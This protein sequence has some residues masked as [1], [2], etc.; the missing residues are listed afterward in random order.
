MTSPS[1]FTPLG[2]EA[3]VLEFAA[4]PPYAPSSGPLITHTPYHRPLDATRLGQLSWSEPLAEDRLVSDEG[5][6]A[7][8]LLMNVYESDMLFLPS[9]GL[10][11][12]EEAFSSFYDQRRRQNA[13]LVRPLV[14]SFAFDFLDRSVRITGEWTIDALHA[15][16][17][18]AIDETI[19]ADSD[20]LLAI[21]TSA[22]RRR[23]AEMLLAQMALDGLTE[24][25]AMSQNLGGAYGA[26]QS[27]LFKIFIDE[28]GYGVFDTKHSTLFGELCRSIGMVADAHRYWFFYLPSWIASNNYFYYVTRNRTAFFRYVGGMAYL[29]AT[30]AP[31]FAAMTRV[32]R[33]IYGGTVDTR[34]CD[35]HAHIDQHHGRMAVEDLLLPMARKHGPLAIQD[36]V[37]GIEE[38]RLLGRIADDDL[39][40]QIRWQ[41][42]LTHAPDPSPDRREVRTLG[43][44]TAFETS[45]AERDTLVSVVEGS[46]DLHWTAT[47]DPLRVHA[48]QA[49]LVP[50][51]RLHGLRAERGAT[52]GLEPAA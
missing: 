38:V 13:E 16:I 46:V 24:A 30:F 33:T 34:Y 10:V 21:D 44:A 39:L 48:G 8:R 1:M 29:E 27:E 3:A 25:T 4:G 2:S 18:A 31:R 12:Q 17:T 14:E 49:V 20:V 22:D 37:R 52:V 51:G 50:R 42:A 36:M 5:L 26:E 35:E 11:G 23:A 9:S 43:P 28:F 6:V 45:V 15:H 47:G 19:H 7:H 40:A 32:L 41:P